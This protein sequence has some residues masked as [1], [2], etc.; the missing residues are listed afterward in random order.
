MRSCKPLAVVGALCA[1]LLTLPAVAL[2]S[3]GH[4]AGELIVPTSLLPAPEV[5]DSL[6][7]VLYDYA[8]FDLDLGTLGDQLRATGGLNLYLGNQAFPLTLE[9]NDLRDPAYRAVLMVDGQ[10]VEQKVPVGTYRG[11]VAGDAESIVR[12]T[13]LPELFEGYVWTAKDWVFIDPVANYSPGAPM[14]QV[15]VYSEQDVRPEAGGTCGSERYHT[16]AK[17]FSPSAVPD[18][19]T[20]TEAP[21]RVDI[22]TEADGQ[23]YQAYGNPGLFN[24]I[25]SVIN[26]VDGIYR[27]QLNLTL[28]IVYQ[29]AWSSVS[30]DPYTSLNA[31]TTLNQF[32]SW[33]NSNR[34]ENR[35]I[36]HQWSGKDFSGGTVGIAWVGVVCNAPGYSYGVSQDQSSSFLRTQLTAHEIG[37]NFSAGHDNQSPVCSGVSCSGSGPLMCSFLQSSGSNQFSSC[38]QSSIASHTATYSGCLN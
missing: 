3:S 22:A 1:L 7:A 36:A 23:Y 30:G 2:P 20:A 25:N 33:W 9:V 38:S 18:G 8:V 21:R 6:D 13:V 12:L 32:R 4:D 35:D 31:S 17:T 16:V 28:N 27:S 24:R 34:P 37:H 5:Q 15:V 29:Q 14:N 19:G 11:T 26:S 10:E